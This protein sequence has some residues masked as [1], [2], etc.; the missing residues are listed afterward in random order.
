MITSLVRRVVPF[1]ALAGLLVGFMRPQQVP[2]AKADLWFHLRFGQEFLDGWSLQAPGNLGPF[3]TAHWIPTQ[4]L[5]QVAM[6]WAADRWGLDSVIWATGVVVLVLVVA[7]FATCRQLAAPL[8]A[9]MAVVLGTL[10]ASPGF[11]ARPQVLSY[12]FVVLTVAAWFATRRDGR[13]RW[14]LVPLAWLWP[15]CHGMWPVGISIS[16]AAVVG[17]ALERRFTRAQLTRMAAIPVSSAVVATLTPLWFD[18]YRSLVTVGSRTAY[19]GEWGAP[20]FTTPPAAVLAVMAVVVIANGMRAKPTPWMH[21]ALT[22][23]ALAW[24]LYSMRTTVVGALILTP[25][26]AIAL[27]RLVPAGDRPS[28]R[29][30][31]ALAATAGVACAVLWPVVASQPD[32]DV[33]PAWVDARLDAM[34]PGARLL[35][36]W[37]TGSWFVYRHPDLSLVMH[38]YGDV[39]TDAEIERNHDLTNLAPG[40]DDQLAELDV[41]AALLV[42]DS[43]LGY[44]L[45]RVLGWDVEQ[46]DDDFVLLLPP[47]G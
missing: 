23:L 45:E 4:W 20:D 27:A 47:Q 11:S 6:A 30:R 43:P 39:F 33:V 29:E 10:A 38:G 12:L 19:F 18:T 36:D 31:V 13:A 24:S 1:V 32:K 5:P 9:A 41:D 3:D 34:A 16:A 2:P 21:V 42:P 15:M 28:R 25:L 14:W 44:T 35:N 37:D 26:L 40:W 17:L 22:A 8:P 46:Q 7:L